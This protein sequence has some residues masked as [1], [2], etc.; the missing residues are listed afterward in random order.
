MP[1]CGVLD[2]RLCDKRAKM[3]RPPKSNQAFAVVEPSCVTKSP[4]RLLF[5]GVYCGNACSPREKLMS[6]RLFVL[7]Q[8]RGAC[9]PT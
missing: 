6:S 7:Y 3:E 1:A 4:R 5:Y 9:A 2:G 8:L